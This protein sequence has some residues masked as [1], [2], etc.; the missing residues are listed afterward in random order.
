LL[1]RLGHELGFDE[2]GVPAVEID[3]R[4]VSS[5]VI[6]Q[7]V[8][9]GD[10]ATAARLLGREYTILGTV[11][12]GLHLGRTLGFPTANLSAHNEQFPPNGVYVVEAPRNGDAPLRGVA[13]IG[14]RPTL[15]QASGERVL[16]VHLFDFEGD[17]Y[18]TDLEI[19]FRQF[20]RPEQKFPSPRSASENRSPAT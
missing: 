11:V 6:R 15:A 12:E 9:C 1:D 20:L 4:I 2:V 5:T 13:N 14:V 19:V 16:E 17:L 3:G 7:A 10:F 8:E 18:G